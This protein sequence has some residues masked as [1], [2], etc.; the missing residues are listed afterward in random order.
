MSRVTSNESCPRGGAG[1]A[2]LCS[3]GFGFIVKPIPLPAEIAAEG[4]ASA[5]SCVGDS[6]TTASVLTAALLPSAAPCWAAWGQNQ[7]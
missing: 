1:R 5:C 3:V 6:F 7:R 4:E 2:A